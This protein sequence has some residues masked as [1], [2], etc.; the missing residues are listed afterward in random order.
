VSEAP[1]F[2]T[3]SEYAYHELRRRILDGEFRPGQRLLLRPV[4]DELG[5]SVM[6][7]RDAMRMLERDGLVTT[8]SHRG[9]T[10][11]PL[12]SSLIADAI[13]I[14][15]WLEVLAVRQAVPRHTPESCDEIRT[16]YTEADRVLDEGDGLAYAG[17]NR[18]LHEAIERP[19]SE[20]LRTMITD[21]WE[22]LWQARRRMS[23]F[24]VLPD[25][26]ASAQLEHRELVAAVEAGDVAGAGAVM[27]R[28]RESTL[29][30]WEAALATLAQTHESV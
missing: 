16:L 18:R 2:I 24:S 4:A 13:S 29:V 15:M 14:R 3:K 26:R 9:A 6:P 10:V 30:A 7:V 21:T 25:S 1:V 12:S 5:L 11:T 28:H 27:E 17:A 23:L 22:R 20:A 8:Q 19:A